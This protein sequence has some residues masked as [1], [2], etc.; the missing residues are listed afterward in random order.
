M[1][2]NKKGV[3]KVVDPK[4]DHH[5][6]KCLLQNGEI[7]VP[8]AEMIKMCKK[9]SSF[10]L[11]DFAPFLE[12]AEREAKKRLSEPTFLHEPKESLITKIQYFFRGKG[13]PLP[14]DESR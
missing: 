13:K 14:Y 12:E 10:Y 11:K 8:L 5:I 1:A 2:I 4:V 3:P 6:K 7:Y 9:F